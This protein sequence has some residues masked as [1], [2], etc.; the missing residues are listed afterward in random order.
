MERVEAWVTIR[1]SRASLSVYPLDGTGARLAPLE[2]AAVPG[3]FR[4]H[5]N[6]EGQPISPW[7]E[8]VE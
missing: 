1:S 7:Y 4:V 3:G 6:A 8:V 2:V 5:L